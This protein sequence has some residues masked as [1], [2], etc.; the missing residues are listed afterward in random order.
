MSIFDLT[1][2]KCSSYVYQIRDSLLFL[3]KIKPIM[4]LR[5]IQVLFHATFISHIAYDISFS[6]SLFKSLATFI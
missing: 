6:S 2:G 5:T 1:D 3:F 4:A